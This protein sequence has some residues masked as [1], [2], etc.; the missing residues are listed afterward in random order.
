MR[1]NTHFLGAGVG[2]S[3]YLT[4]IPTGFHCRK[5][6]LVNIRDVGCIN[7]PAFITTA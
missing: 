3:V 7:R 4:S 6:K 5:L 2:F 1:E